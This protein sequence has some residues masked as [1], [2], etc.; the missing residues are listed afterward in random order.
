MNRLKILMTTFCFLIVYSVAAQDKLKHA[1]DK[2]SKR[3]SKII[4]IH[5]LEGKQCVIHILPHYP[6]GVLNINYHK[7]T[8][9]ITD[10]WG[11]YTNIRVLDNAFLE[12]DYA[13]RGGSNVGVGNTLVF[14]VSRNHLRK[15]MYVMKYLNG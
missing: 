9:A 13:I 3:D 15:C 1:D 4:F 12:I 10:Y 14:C 7:D 11:A 2:A 6:L 5:S 8:I